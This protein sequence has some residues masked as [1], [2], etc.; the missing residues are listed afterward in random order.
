M[1]NSKKVKNL[2]EKKSMTILI[3]GILGWVVYI[4]GSIVDSVFAGNISEEALAGVEIVV[5]FYTIILFVACLFCE[6]ASIK[7]SRYLGEG[8]TKEARELFGHGLFSCILSGIVIAS[9]MYF[10][11]GPFLRISI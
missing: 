11:K 9:L 6:G 5:P 3:A 2:I 4:I 8:K 1:K 7:F 10:L